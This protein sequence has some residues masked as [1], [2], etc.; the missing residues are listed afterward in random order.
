MERLAR[1]TGVFARRGR[2]YAW[3]VSGGRRIRVAHLEGAACSGRRA[4]LAQDA[5]GWLRHEQSP[6]HGLTLV[7]FPAQLELTLSLS[8]QLKLALSPTQPKLTRGCAPKVLKLS[9]NVSNVS[10]RS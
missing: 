6:H 3:C 8:A 9:S 2:E 10:R 7:P 5:A 1:L 4:A